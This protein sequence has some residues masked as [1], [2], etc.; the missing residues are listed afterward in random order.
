MTDM[1][2]SPTEMPYSASQI[3]NRSRTHVG[4]PVDSAPRATSAV[5]FAKVFNTAMVKSRVPETPDFFA[6]LFSLMETPEFKA[7]TAAAQTLS[8]QESI[9]PQEASERMIRVFRKMDQIWSS[10]LC[11]EGRERVLNS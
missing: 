1:E 6:E 8:E 3:S 9:S 2:E 5:D 4:P 11:Q 7:L 10:Y